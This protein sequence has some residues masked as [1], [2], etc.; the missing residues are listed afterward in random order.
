MNRTKIKDNKNPSTV[1][2]PMTTGLKCD[3]RVGYTPILVLNKVNIININ[4]QTESVA[5]L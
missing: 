2:L 3:Y 5:L 4:E 1:K